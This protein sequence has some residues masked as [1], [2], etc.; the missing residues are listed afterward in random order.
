VFPE[1]EVGGASRAE[2]IELAVAVEISHADGARLG[3]L[4][5]NDVFLPFLA[6][7]RFAGILE[8]GEVVAGPGRGGD[9][10]VAVP[11]HVDQ[12]NVVRALQIGGDDVP[13]PDLILC[14]LAAVLEPDQL[15]CFVLDDDHVRLAV[16][17]DVADGVTLEPAFFVL[18]DEVT[19]EIA[20]TIVFVPV[21]GI[22]DGI[23]ADEIE[24]TV[25]IE[26][27]GGYAE[28]VAVAVGNQVLGEVD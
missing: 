10:E 5:V 26:V 12:G 3:D 13:L 16:A 11:I 8:P 15:A 2:Q 7:P 20:L 25:A 23:A 4:L 28:G 19:A 24:I 21:K 14:R 27:R 17:V 22:I 6:Q 9:V 1:D 18:L